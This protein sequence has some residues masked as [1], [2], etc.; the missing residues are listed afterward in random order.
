MKNV[1]EGPALAVAS[2]DFENRINEL[3]R[4]ARRRECEF[5]RLQARPT[6]KR[7]NLVEKANRLFLQ[8]LVQSPRGR[9]HLLAQVAHA[10]AS[11]E[12]AVFER[13]ASLASDPEVQRLIRRHHADEVE[14]AARLWARV[15]ELGVERPTLP[16]QLNVA[17]GLDARLGVMTRP[18][19]TPEDLMR[20]YC[21]LQVLEERVVWQ[22]DLF[23]EVLRPI[24]PTTADLFAALLKDEERHLKYCHAITRRF[25]PSPA[26]L[27]ATLRHFRAAEAAE[28][29]VNGN[30]SLTFILD[31][32]LLD[33]PR[34][35]Q[36]VWRGLGAAARVLRKDTHDP[37][38]ER[39]DAPEP[40]RERRRALLALEPRIASLFGFDR[41][42]IAVTL[43]VAAAQLALAF[44][45]SS[46]PL[47]LL[48]PCAY[49][50]G[51]VLSHWL[52]QS[53]HETSH[54]LAAKTP[55]AN[56]VLAWVANAPMV[57]PMSETFH[58]YHLEHHV[59]LGTEGR[60]SDLPLPI[61]LDVIGTNRAGKL[62]WLALYPLVYLLRGARYARR[63][64]SA[65]LLQLATMLLINL[66]L[67]ELLG[68][69]GVAY[70]ALSTFFGHGLHPVAAHF[71]HE[72]YLFEGRQETHSYDGPL[73][74][75]TFNVGFHVEHHDFMNIPG[76]RLPAYRALM[77]QHG[78]RTAAHP[79][80]TRVLFDFI[81]R[82]DLGPRARLVRTRR[83]DEAQCARST[84]VSPA[85]CSGMKATDISASAST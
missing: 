5:C 42:T 7:M 13:L 79:S 8:Q 26:T 9:A 27:E 21:F 28:F 31:E 44:V 40:H 61:E 25:A 29:E 84:R 2:A 60:D 72:H 49:A 67:W 33:E 18:L 75:V 4:W 59:H 68:P 74:L 66:A 1:R 73:N 48:V 16:A 41:R 51:A 70:L 12:V 30:L 39:T 46:A 15:D 69:L 22:F 62:A 37:R 50:V 82:D 58:R 14:H 81:V 78:V 23:I 53:I 6:V 47:W 54:H 32:R 17:A 38:F 80:W 36:G 76:W 85:L 83:S 34:W 52:G 10:E 77:A 65:E 45:L 56:R 35:V 43:V 20:A 64:S 24:D 55:L 71:I 57:V 11:G 19:D 63:I 3:H